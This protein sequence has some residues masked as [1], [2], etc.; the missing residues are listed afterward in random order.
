MKYFLLLLFVFIHLCA[1]EKLNFKISFGKCGQFIDEI[2]GV[3]VFHYMPEKIYNYIHEL[4]VIVYD[5]LESKI[6]PD[7][8]KSV[9]VINKKISALKNQELVY[10]RAKYYRTIKNLDDLMRTLDYG[11]L[12]SAIH[13]SS[14][15][16]PNKAIVNNLN[17][18]F[19]NI[20]YNGDFNDFKQRI[21]NL[22]FDVDKLSG[23]GDEINTNRNSRRAMEIKAT[24]EYIQAFK[25]QKLKPLIW[26]Y[27]D[28]TD[29]V[30]E[31]NFYNMEKLSPKERYNQFI[32]DKMPDIF[33]FFEMNGDPI[34]INET[35]KTFSLSNEDLG[36]YII[37]KIKMFGR[38][39]YFHG[40]EYYNKKHTL[41]LFET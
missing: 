9:S 13:K 31:E 41:S 11:I 1:E 38:S 39:F 30:L 21:E 8:S 17:F 28:A 12:L 26:I 40:D 10:I 20:A 4:D 25:Y 19:N 24:K 22:K 5:V 36:V 18:E 33:E 6:S 3:Y 27:E 29:S 15:V 14:N 2:E 37:F 32:T 16:S 34:E 7:K 23:Y 35:D